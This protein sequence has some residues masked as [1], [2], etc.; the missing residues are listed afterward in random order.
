MTK[1]KGWEK[2]NKKR[3]DREL[4]PDSTHLY[5]YDEM[6]SWGVERDIQYH[7]NAILSK[8]FVWMISITTH[9]GR[10]RVIQHSLSQWKDLSSNLTCDGKLLT[11]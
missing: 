3:K 8:V 4:R 11:F 7:C 2:N 6:V 10:G 9:R 5:I 1:R